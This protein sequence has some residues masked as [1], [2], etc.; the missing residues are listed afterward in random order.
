MKIYTD[1]FRRFSKVI[2]ASYAKGD[3]IGQS[4]YLNFKDSYAYFSDDNFLAKMKF[5]F[6]DENDGISN[7]LVDKKM[8][9]T[10]CHQ[11]EDLTLTE[12]YEFY[13]GEEKFKIPYF[14][15]KQDY[16]DFDYQNFESFQLTSG[17][18]QDMRMA[19]AYMGTYDPHE[20]YFGVAITEN[21][22]VGTDSAEVF[23]AKIDEKDES[24][25]QI[26]YPEVKINSG[27]VKLLLLSSDTEVCYLHYNEDTEDLYFT[28]GDDN[29]LHIATTN[30]N[31][32][33][34]DVTDPDFIDK[35]S[36]DTYF[37]I[38]KQAVEDVLEFFEVFVKNERNERVFI[39][40]ADE[41]TLSVET[42]SE[43]QGNRNVP[44]KECSRE[45]IDDG[46]WVP[47]ALVAKAINSINDDFIVFEVDSEAPA[48]NI[49]GEA[50]TDRHVS[51]VRLG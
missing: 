49:I 47:R 27:L 17:I 41:N 51:I 31:L 37:T 22:I 50:N 42:Q 14:L 2:E 6:D 25:N 18:L 19:T 36:H 13:N 11:Y 23:E 38:E 8:F 26:D 33:I 44:I 10:L 28:L 15:D 39:R 7:I 1:N 16:P 3:R 35:Y 4:I 30:T 40:V 5:E 24:G 12:D 32:R 45:L 9:L 43:T 20:N 34:P 48:F 46:I 21:T 29:Q